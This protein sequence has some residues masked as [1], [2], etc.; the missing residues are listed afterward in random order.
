[1]GKF[2]RAREAWHIALKQWKALGREDKVGDVR[3]MLAD[4]GE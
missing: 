4:M 1:M 2:T 3:E